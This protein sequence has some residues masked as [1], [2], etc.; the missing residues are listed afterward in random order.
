MDIMRN[1]MIKKR[2]N[3]T[4]A[5]QL[6]S[7]LSSLIALELLYPSKE[8]FLTSPWLTNVQ[9]LNN[10]YGQFRMITA[11]YSGKIL[12]LRD[13]LILLSDKGCKVYLM[14]SPADHNNAFLRDLP[15]SILVKK[16]KDLH[17]KALVTEGF[18]LRG[19]MNFTYSGININ[20]E[21]IEIT[22]DE[23]LVAMATVEARYH[24]GIA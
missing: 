21:S 18:Y 20:S 3:N 16:E 24:W 14:T 17:E 1:R 23:Q 15:S 7:C 12:G 10:V 5:L 9:I 2:Y 19:S 22:T 8:M 13:L 6:L 4:S 11:C